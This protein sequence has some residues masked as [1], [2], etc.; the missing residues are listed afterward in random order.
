MQ[1]TQQVPVLSDIP[2]LEVAGTVVALGPGVAE[3]TGYAVGDQVFG[4]CPG[5]V[6]GFAELTTIRRAGIERRILEHW[7]DVIGRKIVP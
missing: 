1:P 5:M 2:G 3:A 7:P 4:G 6:G